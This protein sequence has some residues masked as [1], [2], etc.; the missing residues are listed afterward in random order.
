MKCAKENFDEHNNKTRLSRHMKVSSV[1][2]PEPCVGIFKAD[3]HS[4]KSLSSSIAS[5]P[6]PIPARMW[7]REKGDKPGFYVAPL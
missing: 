6:M 2:H 4:M 1:C 7:V 3:L 5:L